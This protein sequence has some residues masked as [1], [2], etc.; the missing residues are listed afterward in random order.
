MKKKKNKIALFILALAVIFLLVIFFR[1]IIYGIYKIMTNDGLSPEARKEQIDA[2]LKARWY[3]F[4]I[5]PAVEALQMVVVFLPSEFI[6]LAAGISFDWWQAIILCDFGVF[7]G[8]SLIYF[9]VRVFKWGPPVAKASQD[10]LNEL[11]NRK[12]LGKGVRSLMHILFVMPAVPFGLT[13]YYGARS[14]K[15]NYKKYILTCVAGVLPSIC[16]SVLIGNLFVYFANKG[17]P[18]WILI[19]CFVL[20]ALALLFLA[21]RVISK[22]YFKENMGSPNSPLYKTLLN[23][24]DGYIKKESITTFEKG[25]VMQVEEPFLA[26]ANHASFFDFYY[27]TKILYPHRVSIVANR[28]YFRNPVLRKIFT[29]VGIIPKKLFTPDIET[30]KRIF[31]S[32]KEGNSILMF[33]EGRLCIDG[34]SYPVTKGTGD[35]VRKLKIPVVFINTEGAFLVNPKWRKKKMRNK[36]HVS[37]RKIMLPEEYAGLSSIEIEK[38]INENIYV[39]NFAFARSKNLVYK[40]HRRAEGMEN[41]LYQCPCCGKDYTV[42]AKDNTLTCSSC[43]M[44]LEVADNYSFKE[45]S[46]AIKDMHEW[47]ERIKENERKKVFAD[48]FHIKAKVRV[49][50]KDMNCSR[51]DKKGSGECILRHSGFV[52]TG[53]IKNEKIEFILPIEHLHALAFSAGKEFECYSGDE[54]YYFYPLENPQQCAKWAL[55]VDL[56]QERLQKKDED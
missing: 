5:V 40:K 25:D 54:L 17:Y 36:V 41:I 35:L 21:G 7:A 4:L 38:E 11:H 45:N 47:Y 32:I 39:D 13:C 43:G 31:K 56:Y 50:V 52:F 53:F 51:K 12:K 9:F 46:L 29:T 8:A 27:S 3:G 19:V 15:V 24:M 34:T 30:I 44:K 14:G 6:Q 55:I 42:S 37:I 20:F 23:L 26:F 1:N 16:T 2:L 18:I 22:T 10:R 28:Y 49:E 48:D 33:P